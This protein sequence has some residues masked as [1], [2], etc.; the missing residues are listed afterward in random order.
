MTIQRGTCVLSHRHWQSSS[1]CIT[2]PPFSSRFQKT[3]S[4]SLRD[5]CSGK[6]WVTNHPTFLHEINILTQYDEMQLNT[7]LQPV[8]AL[9]RLSKYPLSLR[10]KWRA[11]ECLWCDSAQ[12]VQRTLTNN[13]TVACFTKQCCPASSLPP[14]TTKVV[15]GACLFVHLEHHNEYTRCR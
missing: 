10:H 9:K 1:S 8:N 13:G 11:S 7:A 15:R 12:W 2:W 6:C 4:L 5:R 14:I 3:Q